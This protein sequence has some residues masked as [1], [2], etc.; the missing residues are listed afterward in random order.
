MPRSVKK[1]FASK[2]NKKSGLRYL[3]YWMLSFA[4]ALWLAWIIYIPSPEGII[5]EK[6]SGVFHSLLGHSAYLLPLLFLYG[7]IVIVSKLNKP[8]KG[9]ITLISGITLILGSLSC[10]LDIAQ[11]YL[12]SP[13]LFDGGWIGFALD[14]VFSK[15]FGN[16]GSILLSAVM[17][18]LGL[19]ILFKISWAKTI[20]KWSL[21]IISDYKHWMSAKKELQNKL[22][23]FTQRKENNYPSMTPIPE[24]EKPPETKIV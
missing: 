3:V 9:I 16:P 21:A 23:T 22:N 13:S 2:K 18:I 17:F 1:R 15:I 10:A 14:Q 5:A 6:L 4:S 12:I 8:H 24:A 19:Q 7:L 11:H 20:K